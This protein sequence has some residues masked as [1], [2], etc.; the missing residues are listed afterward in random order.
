MTRI[1]AIL[2]LLALL[3]A[4][5]RAELRHRWSFNHSAGTIA[6]GLTIAD[7]VSGAL[8]TV[9]GAGPT[10]TNRASFTGTA[11][12]L[13]GSGNTTN[14]GNAAAN[15]IFPYIDLP[16]GIVSS[17]TNLTVE[18]WATP[19]AHINNQRLFDFGRM[20]IAGV[21]GGA[22]GEVTNNSTTAPGATTTTNVDDLALNIGRSSLNGQRLEGRLN[23]GAA[24]VADSA[25]ATAAN[26]EVHYALVFENG[27]GAFPA[28]GGRAS[29]YAN[30]AFARSIDVN[31]RLANLEDV[32]NWLGRSQYTADPLARIDYNEVRLHDHAF[33]PVEV[34]ASQAVGPNPLS[35]PQPQPDAITMNHGAKAA[36]PVR[37]NDADLVGLEIVQAPQFGTATLDPFGRILYTHTSGTPT[38]DTFLYRGTNLAGASA[39]T[40]VTVTFSSA[41]RLPAPTLNVPSE[42]PPVAYQVVEAFGSLAFTDPVAMTTPPGEDRRLFVAQRGGLLRMIPDVT[43][44][45]PT[46]STFLDLATLLANRNLPA[47]PN[48]VIVAGGERGLLGVA[49]HPNY[50]SN[51]YFYVN[52]C[53]DKDSTT[54]SPIF[55][56]VSRFTVQAGDPNVANPN[57]ELILIEQ[58]D[59][60]GNHNGGDLHFGSD[61]YLYITT[62]DE[63]DQNDTGNNSQRITKDFFCAILRIDVDKR[64]GNLEPNAHPNPADYPSNPPP[65][66]VMRDAGVARYSIPIDNPYVPTGQGGSWTGTFNGT[67]IPAGELP[68]VRSEFWATGFRNLWRMSFDPATGDLWAGDVGGGQREEVNIVTRGGNYGWALREGFID[69]P[70]SAQA[71]ANFDT[72]YGTRPIHDYSHIAGPTGGFSITGGFVFR[73]DRF[74]EL[75]GAYVFADYVTGNIWTIRRSGANGATPAQRIGGEGG[76]SAFAPDPSNG[77]ILMA[78]LDNGRIRRL[79]GG[80]PTTGY[81]ALLSDTGLF[82]DHADLAPN[83]GLVAYDVNLPFWSDHGIKRRWLTIPDTGAAMT[84]SRDGAWTFPTGQVWVKHF[85]LEL[86][87]G[88]PATRRRIETRLLVKTDAGAYGVSY[89]WND[90]QTDATLVPDEGVDLPFTINV[91]GTN[92]PQ[93]WRIPSRSECLSCHT[94][95]AGHALSSNTRQLN[96]SGIMNRFAGNQLTLLR[97]AGYFTNELESPNVLPRHLRP[98][99]LTAP[100][101]TGF[102]LEARVRSY[103]DV[104]C[105]YCHQPGGTGAPAQWD[106]RITTPLD[107]TGLINGPATNNGGNPNHKLI[108]P[109][110]PQFSVVLSRMA[111]TNGY[112]RMPPLGSNELDQANI[113]LVTQWIEST[114]LINR[115]TYADWRLAQFGSDTSAEG[116]PGYDA[117]FDGSDN[118][119]EFTAGT[120]PLDG[121]SFP[122]PLV[123]EAPGGSVTVAVDVPANRTAQIETTTDLTTW[124]LWDI[125]GNGGLATSGGPLTL[126]GPKL[127]PRQFFRWRL[128]EN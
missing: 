26:T 98:E 122:Q 21:G 104:N 23:G 60:F 99:E 86:T 41:L 70:K 71:P 91:G 94:P 106:G 80:V 113:T 107:L 34:A 14:A 89:R 4:S 35:L 15:A 52:Y 18:I 110:E 87:R 39:P 58:L 114:A 124:S 93:T 62:G 3:S 116:E 50:A 112:T 2:V 57:S 33:R 48:E 115:Q 74:P 64:P 40:T 120:A 66:A 17:K 127:G 121:A 7:S 95:A 13:P 12:R 118:A 67:A 38:S 92:T 109:D 59:D 128:R 32:N 126:T 82:A 73:G 53:V 75:F 78:D 30:G 54:A 29:W 81:P 101:N 56:R 16:N 55:Q 85:D 119:G 83:P 9:V 44:A 97:N 46:T 63:G 100:V 51:G 96:L 69:G 24:F 45:T 1:A 37:A 36:I 102:P 25:I 8:A 77:D 65:D 11:L 42:L 49:F 5:A 88:N 111:A 117:D 123:S 79:V 19:V 61:G 10:G 76:I 108:V 31:F 47:H 68:Y 125:P 90:A 28:T 84:W 6:A 27:V 22:A 72:L 43:A 105:A 20:S 103:L